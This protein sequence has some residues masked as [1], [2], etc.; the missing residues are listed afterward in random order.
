MLQQQ[1]YERI[2]S[3]LLKMNYNK[4]YNVAPFTKDQLMEVLQQSNLVRTDDFEFSMDFKRIR[5]CRAVTVP[6]SAYQ[7]YFKNR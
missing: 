3:I 2:K 5:R 4:W 6:K 1:E 7:E